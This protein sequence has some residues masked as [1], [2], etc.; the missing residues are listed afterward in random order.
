MDVK[1]W[2]PPDG[3][4]VEVSYTW[5]LVNVPSWARHKAFE[6]MPGMSKPTED[7][8]IVQQTNNGWKAAF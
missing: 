1:E 3:P 6:D 8:A 4:M 5:K 7:A 2:T